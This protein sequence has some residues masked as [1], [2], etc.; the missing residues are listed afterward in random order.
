M[1]EFSPL[2]NEIFVEAMNACDGFPYPEDLEHFEDL[3]YFPRLEAAIRKCD[4]DIEKSDGDKMEDD[5]EV[6]EAQVIE[7]Y[8]LYSRDGTKL[9][10][11]STR[12]CRTLPVLTTVRAWVLPCAEPLSIWQSSTRRSQPSKFI[13][14]I[15]QRR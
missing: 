4:E 11:V 7:Q 15:L 3:K 8:A 14:K 10:P 9:S 13:M 1:D 5:M 6:V 2:N 12:Q